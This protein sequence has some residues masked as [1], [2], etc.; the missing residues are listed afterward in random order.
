MVKQARVK[1]DFSTGGVVWDAATKKFLLIFVENLSGARVWTFPKGHP[2]NSEADTEAAIRE[3]LEETGWRCDVVKTI[4][5][6]HYFYVHDGVTY[7]KTVRWFLMKPIEKVGD[8]DPEEVIEVRWA[9]PQEAT[10][11]IT[12]GSDKELLK[13]TSVL[14]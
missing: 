4:T 14:L 7:D 13:Q 8:F 5:D 12:Y 1:K 10:T 3:V 2:E 9:S 6:V 11:M